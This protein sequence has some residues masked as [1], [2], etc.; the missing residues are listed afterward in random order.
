MAKE[1]PK[2]PANEKPADSDAPEQAAAKPKSGKR[3]KV[4]MLLAA[5]L[6]ASGGGGGWFYMRGSQANAKTA[7]P[8]HKAAPPTFV[9]L[10]TFTVNLADREHFLQLGVAYEVKGTTI[11]D[12]MKIHMPILRSRILLLLSSRSSDDLG[13]PDGKTKLAEQLVALA[14]G[15]VVRERRDAHQS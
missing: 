9:S 15:V 10:E 8:V 4:I 2:S 7:E 6:L 12:A 11:I 1:K 13:S 14:R 3:R 5:L